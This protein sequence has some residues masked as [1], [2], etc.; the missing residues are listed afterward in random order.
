MKIVILGGLGQ[1]GRIT[2]RDLVQTWSGGEVI[3]GDRDEKKANNF[4]SSFKRKNVKGTGVDIMKHDN[5]VKVLADAK[6]VIASIPYKLNLHVMNA[7]VEAGCN[8]LDLGGLFH[9]TRKQLK[10]HNKFKKKGLIGVLGCGSTPGTTN[11]MAKYGADQFDR[12]DEIN[13]TFA[14][15]DKAKHKKHFIVP[16]SMYTVF[17]EFSDR[18]AVFT[19]RKLKFVEPL[20]GKGDII[21]P[22][23]VGKV[24]GYYTLHSELATFPSSFKKKGLKECWFKVTFD[25]DFIHDVKLLIEAGLASEEYINVAGQ[26]VKPIDVTVKQL[27]RL[28]PTGKVNDMEYIR[29]IMKGERKDRKVELTL[30]SVAH[31]NPNW[32]VSAGA[33]NTGVPPSIIAQ[34]IAKGQVKQKG[35]LPPEI[36]INPQIFFAE[37]KKRDIKVYHT[38]KEQVN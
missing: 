18:P 26:R 29:V 17:H 19:N 10:L 35:V 14:G 38:L 34:M 9:M 12:I 23:P 15:Y 11:V 25:P 33:I 22:D 13:I 27:N 6:V 24:T 16:Y 2:T 37:L 4:A 3:I 20:S 28:I 36:C 7:A 1:M 21:F 30:D 31:S 5:L 8:Y 32:N